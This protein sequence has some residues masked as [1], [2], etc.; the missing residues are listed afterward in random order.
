MLRYEQPPIFDNN[1]LNIRIYF[2]QNSRPPG[3]AT[4]WYKKRPRVSGN[5]NGISYAPGPALPIWFPPMGV[6][7]SLKRRKSYKGNQRAN[8]ENTADIFR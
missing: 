7:R 2:R 5:R 6:S 8:A 4:V 3:H 1:A